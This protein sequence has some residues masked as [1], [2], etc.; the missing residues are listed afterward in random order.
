MSRLDLQMRRQTKVS[1][2]FLQRT[3]NGSYEE[4][5]S[6]PKLPWHQSER[7]G[8]MRMVKGSRSAL[9]DTGAIREEESQDCKIRE[10]S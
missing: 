2:A 1:S 10:Q 8:T 9:S 7:R 5:I 4:K 6:F 3:T